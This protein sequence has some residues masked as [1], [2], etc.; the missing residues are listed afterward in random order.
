MSGH[1][2]NPEGTLASEFE[3]S[4]LSGSKPPARVAVSRSFALAAAVAVGLAYYLGAKIGFALTFQPNPISL[5]WP[6]NALLLAALLLTPT[7]IW[8]WLVTAALPAHLAVEL[9]SGVPFAMVIGWFV[10]NCGEA[11]FGAA[12]IRWFAGDRLR[13]TSFRHV[14]IFLLFGVLV[15]PFLSSFLDVAFVKLAGWGHTDYGRM[16]RMRFFSNALAALALVPAIVTWV[17]M[18]P[19]WFRGLPLRRAA[20]PAAFLVG[21]LVTSIAVF[22]ETGM[23]SS[24]TPALLYVPLPFLLWAALRLGPIAVSTGLL[25]ITGFAVGGALRGIG[26]FSTGSAEESA[27]AIQLFL[28]VIGVPKLLLMAGVAERR[29]AKDALQAS[30]VRFASVFRSNPDPMSIVNPAD[31]KLLDVNQRWE[32]MFGFARAEVIGRTTA[33]L[34]IYVDPRDRDR[35]LEAVRADGGVRDFEVEQ[36]DKTGCPRTVLLTGDIIDIGGENRLI[37]LAR[38]VTG[39]RQAEREATEQRRQVAQLNRAAMLGELSGAL[40][41][42]LNQPLGAIL[43]NTFAAENLIAREPIDV[44]LMNH[45]V[46]DIAADSRRAADVIR[47]LRAMLQGASPEPRTIRA[48]ELVDAALHLSRTD[49]RERQ[50]RLETRVAPD[51]PDV[52]GDPIQL[53]Q[54]L[55][56]LVINACDAMNENAPGTRHLAIQAARTEADAVQ[57]SVIDRGTGIAEDQLERVFQP[58]VTTKAQGL[59]LGLPICRSIV[60]AHRGRIWATRNTEGGMSFH[61][62]L[63]ALAH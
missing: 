16:V 15:A 50:V 3:P 36:I 33:E 39:Q 55:L 10:S 40:A 56:N 18:G 44:A 29:R 47:H 28:I 63:P 37:V 48:A 57:F 35:F 11:L 46:H 8:W 58:F 19:A 32:S 26:P 38:D 61:V 4:E 60:S 52:H 12:C 31:G 45:I 53:Q 20:E 9:E 49:L 7:R 5:L 27:L 59:G 24:A 30:E 43:C 1:A 51:L 21:L 42:E 17:T 34:K 25:L 41:H 22:E 23:E 13:F 14:S 6:P 62:S 2:L 54:V